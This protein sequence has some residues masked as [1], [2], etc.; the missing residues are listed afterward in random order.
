MTSGG[1]VH[2]NDIGGLEFS[3]AIWNEFMIFRIVG[4]YLSYPFCPASYLRVYGLTQSCLLKLLYP[5]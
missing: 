1:F 3:P 5:L 4:K 2:G